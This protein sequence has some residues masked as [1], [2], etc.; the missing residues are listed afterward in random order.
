MGGKEDAEEACVMHA[1]AAAKSSVEGAREHVT[2][3]E[4]LMMRAGCTA[5]HLNWKDL[6]ERI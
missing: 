5:S 3:G 4:G 1:P 6:D 2:V